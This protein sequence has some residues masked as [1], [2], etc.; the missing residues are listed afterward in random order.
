[1]DCARRRAGS[2]P[3]AV[4]VSVRSSRL[5]AWNR[6]RLGAHA[7]ARGEKRVWCTIVVLQNPA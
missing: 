3:P 7:N 2:E 6:L 1:M 4:H 5:F